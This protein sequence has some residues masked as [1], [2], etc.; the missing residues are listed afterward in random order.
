MTQLRNTAWIELQ[1]RQARLLVEQGR[2]GEAQQ[3]LARTEAALGNQLDD[4]QL[5]AALAGAHAD[6]GNT[7][8]ALTLAQRLVTGATPSTE[9]RLQYAQ[10][11]H[12]R[13]RWLLQ[14]AGLCGP[15]IPGAL[16][17]P[18]R[19]ADGELE[20]GRQHRCAA[21]HHR[22]HAV[23]PDRSHL[24]AGRLR[25]RL[26]RVVAGP[27]QPL[28]RPGVRGRKPH[29]RVL[30]PQWRGR[31]AGGT[32]VVPGRA[33]DLQQRARLQPVQQQSL[34][35]F[36]AGSAGFRAGPRAAGTDFAVRGGSLSQRSAVRKVCGDACARRARCT[37]GLQRQ[38]R[39]APC[40]AV[41]VTP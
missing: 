5:L 30:Q 20:G 11:F 12:L 40:G 16:E 25:C 1:A 4:P 38:R 18:Q 32:A 9:D 10:R 22:S 17:R 28:Y 31:M 23:F 37:P 21:F 34:S 33:H 13:P 36:R 6:A 8:R 41:P 24:A 27:G 35:A 39:T 19:R 29:R 2:A 15:G 14:P 26:C 3:L 7:P